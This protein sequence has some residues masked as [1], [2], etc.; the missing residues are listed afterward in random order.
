M[1][2][3]TIFS[4]L[5]RW[6]LNSIDSLMSISCQFN[7]SSL[8][9]ETLPSASFHSHP[10]TG[11]ASK[12]TQTIFYT[13]PMK[14]CIQILSPGYIVLIHI[15]FKSRLGKKAMLKMATQFTDKYTTKVNDTV[16]TG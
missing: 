11:H 12:Y 14:P 9:P 3:L 6:A 13:K 5:S 16:P 4:I 15:N 2:W 7:S 10:F 8:T 1:T